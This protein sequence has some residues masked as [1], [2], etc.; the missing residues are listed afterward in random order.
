M[1]L[2]LLCSQDQQSSSSSK[3][4][5]AVGGVA[6]QQGTQEGKPNSQIL[7]RGPGFTVEVRSV[8]QGH[9][10]NEVVKCTEDSKEKQLGQLRLVLNKTTNHA[11]LN[12]VCKIHSSCRCWISNVE[13]SDLLLQWLGAAD[14]CSHEV[15]QELAANLKQSI[16]IA[17]RR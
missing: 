11:S 4:A 9:L 13:N 3:H 14:S 17:I 16:G 2:N 7:E 6:V 15:H 1:A 8:N 10:L 5:A 12:A